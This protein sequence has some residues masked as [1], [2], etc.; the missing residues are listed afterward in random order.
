MSTQY[1]PILLIGIGSSG[2]HILEQVQNFYYEKT[3]QNKP[4]FVEFIYIETNRD[5]HPGITAKKNEVRQVY[6]SLA[7]MKTMIQELKQAHGDSMSW[8]PPENH[9]LEAGSGA[10]G[11][12]ACGRLALW[13]KN[14][15][16]NNLLNVINAV[17]EIFNKVSGPNAR[18]S[19]GAEPAVFITGSL[20]G[21][22]GSGIFLDLAYL[23]RTI[24]P[25]IKDLYSLLL[26]PPEP[27]VIRGKEVLYS[28]TYGALTALAH[29]NNADQ[30]YTAPN[31]TRKVFQE[32]PFE[33]SQFIAQSYND[34]TPQLYTLNGLYK[35]A[36]LYLFLNIIGLRAKR[37]ERLV[38][39]RG[40]MQI[41]KYGT[42]GLSAIQYP[43]AQIQEYLSLDLST[44]LLNR[45]IN[46]ENYLDK[47]Q[48]MPIDTSRIGREMNEHFGQFLTSAFDNLN[49]A[50]GLNIHKEIRKEAQLIARGQVDNV[51]DYLYNLYSPANLEGYYSFVSNNIQTGVDSLIASI[52]DYVIGSFNQY[53][54]LFY[55]KMQIK[56]VALSIKSI[57]RYWQSLGITVHPAKWEHHLQSQASWMAN[58]RYLLLF[59]QE[60]VLA[61][62]MLTTFEQLKMHLFIEKLIELG[63]NIVK[64]E[65]PLRTR[66]LSQVYDL[67]ILHKIEESIR[68]IHRTIGKREDQTDRHRRF[69]SLQKRQLE[70]EEDMRDET[71][72]I[73][74]IFPAGSFREEVKISADN[75]RKNASR[76]YPSKVTL[77]QENSLWDYLT[78]NTD[79]LHERLYFDCIQNFR[80]ELEEMDAIR[81]YN[82][83][84]YVSKYPNVAKKYAA[85]AISYLLP[86]R[87]KILERTQNIPKVVIGSEKSV[88][89]RVISLLRNENFYEFE[90]NGDNILEIPELHNIMVFYIEQGNFDPRVDISYMEEVREIDRH[91][92]ARINGMD[93]N[94]WFT[95]RNPYLRKTDWTELKI[96]LT[97]PA[98]QAS[99]NGNA[100]V[101]SDDQKA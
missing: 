69:K 70:I 7:N 66:N 74:R 80:Q 40:N 36:G 54:S 51:A 9:A 87:D 19:N 43:K 86:I 25:G 31:N 48:Q 49:A 96:A 63:T 32:P 47:N 83:S 92:P 64:G 29:F 4:D 41:G 26:L 6:I 95:F 42:F 24:I 81:N 84:D 22:T 55:T 71:I 27:D 21:G 60:A 100:N 45:W 101:T 30:K 39:A 78:H 3:N 2:M 93:E 58:K 89:E 12:P 98:D 61:D 94:K 8:L 56:A 88:I 5:N 75:Y 77:I 15:E 34:S 79:N 85:K 23:V 68:S 18:D 28:N 91:Y 73:L 67:P 46:P 97:L 11:I 20:T 82:V 50:G 76:N 57:I 52:S 59:E 1:Q 38:D 72:P 16:G 33:L 44:K 17:K 35:M 10:G 90:S 53:E 65:I 13:G 14:T 62:R 37:R 99:Q